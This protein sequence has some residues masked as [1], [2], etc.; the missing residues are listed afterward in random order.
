[1][2]SDDKVY[3]VIDIEKI[4]CRFLPKEI[5]LQQVLLYLKYGEDGL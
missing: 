1:M 4:V 3:S 5:S 2:N